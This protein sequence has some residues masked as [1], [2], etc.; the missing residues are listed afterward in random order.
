MTVPQK[1]FNAIKEGDLNK[2]KESIYEG[3][4]IN[5]QDDF[6]WTAAHSVCAAGN[7]EAIK[8]LHKLGAN[9]EAKDNQGNSPFNLAFKKLNAFLKDKLS[10]SN[11]LDYTDII[12]Y[13]NRNK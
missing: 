3:T 4:D 13:I 11:A 10:L 6:G 12:A 5:I 1:F 9:I 2:L 8:C 7:L